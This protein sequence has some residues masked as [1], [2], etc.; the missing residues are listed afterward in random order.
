M[1]WDSVLKLW[2][3]VYRESHAEFQVK[4]AQSQSSNSVFLAYVTV[5]QDQYVL[6]EFC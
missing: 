1:Y 6:L 3:H 5:D 2:D 4:N